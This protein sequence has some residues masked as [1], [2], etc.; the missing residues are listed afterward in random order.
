MPLLALLTL[1]CQIACGLHVVRR[2]QERYW[3]YLIIALPGLGCLIYALAIMLPEALGSRTGRHTVRT[4]HDRVDPQRHLRPLLDDLA[5]RDTRESRERLARELLRLGRPAEA[6][7]HFLAALTGI[8]AQDPDL[9]LGL[10]ETSFVLEDFA[11]CR[12]VLERLIQHNPQ[13]RSE[14]GHLLYARTLEKLGDD[15]GA[16]AEFRALVGYSTGPEA[17]YRY[18]LLLKRHRRLREAGELLEQ[19]DTYARR[20]PRYYRNLHKEFLKLS[21]QELQTLRAPSP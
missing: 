4:L 7:E 21:H 3:L 18:A 2:G 12:Q 11:Q 19:I 20:A 9:L 16:E 8:H 10:A 1:A 6:K 17:R 5:L 15:D 13:Y 14:A